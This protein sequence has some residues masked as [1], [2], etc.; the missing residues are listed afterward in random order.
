MEK[1]NPAF[2]A[3]QL[4]GMCDEQRAFVL[5]AENFCQHVFL[6]ARRD[7]ERDAGTHGN[8]GRLNLRRHAAMAVSLSVPPASF[9]IVESI[10]SMTEIVFGLALLKFSITPSPWSK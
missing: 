7:D 2:A 4:R 9:S 6:F 8:L 3:L 1:R 5:A 10:F